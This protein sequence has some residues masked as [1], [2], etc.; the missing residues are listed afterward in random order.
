LRIGLKAPPL[1]RL[2]SGDTFTPPKPTQMSITLGL[3]APPLT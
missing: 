1:T 3:K 2:T